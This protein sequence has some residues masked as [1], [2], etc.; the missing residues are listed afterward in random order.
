MLTYNDHKLLQIELDN[1]DIQISGSEEAA[2][3]MNVTYTEFALQMNYDAVYK[4]ALDKCKEDTLCKFI[5]LI[6]MMALY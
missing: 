4:K 1:S 3:L 6:N 5:D 2:V